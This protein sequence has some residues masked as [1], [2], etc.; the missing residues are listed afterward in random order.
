M[1]FYSI[2]LF[3]MNIKVC[4]GPDWTGFPWCLL[5]SVS[6]WADFCAGIDYCPAQLGRL[7]PVRYWVQRQPNNINSLVCSVCWHPPL[8]QHA[9]VI[10]L[11]LFYFIF[12]H[13][14]LSNKWLHF[15]FH[16]M[17]HAGHGSCC[18]FCLPWVRKAAS[19]W[20]LQVLQ[21]GNKNICSGYM[22]VQTWPTA[23]NTRVWK[24][25][26]GQKHMFLWR[27]L[28][29]TVHL[30]I[31]QPKVTVRAQIKLHLSVVS[32]MT[33]VICSIVFGVK[34]D[35]VFLWQCKLQPQTTA[36]VFHSK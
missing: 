4:L 33:S 34:C 6:H 35:A 19:I 28:N 32:L 13:T 21:G 7:P 18:Q 15:S 2:S 5:V 1:I 30:C 9:T 12:L 17:Q 20:C 10:V 36:W 23:L 16:A 3:V 26:S 27:Q 14:V 31:V 24:R 25:P 22:H 29:S 11:F 8:L